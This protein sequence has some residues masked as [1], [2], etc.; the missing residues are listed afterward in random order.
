[1]LEV[2]A[3]PPERGSGRTGPVDLVGPSASV[4]IAVVSAAERVDMPRRRGRVRGRGQRLQAPPEIGTRI[5]DCFGRLPG[6]IVHDIGGSTA[7]RRRNGR[8]AGATDRGASR[9]QPIQAGAGEEARSGSCAASRSFGRVGDRRV[10][11][12]SE[13]SGRRVVRDAG[14]VD[15]PADREQ[16]DVD[17]TPPRRWDRPGGLAP[18]GVE[19][20]CPG[21]APGE[22]HDGDRDADDNRLHGHETGHGLFIGN[23]AERA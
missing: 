4:E 17:G 13:K 18:A 12:V 23:G 19:P 22:E 7:C 21:P 11:P 3:L 2:R 14:R 8:L 6:G 5:P 1:M 20:G 9:V 10:R 16:H 15:E